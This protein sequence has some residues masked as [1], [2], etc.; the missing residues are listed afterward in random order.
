VVKKHLKLWLKKILGN[1]PKVGH[2]DLFYMH[3]SLNRLLQ[4]VH[5]LL[6]KGL[7]DYIKTMFIVSCK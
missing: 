2:C 5:V 1:V 3:C 6:L 4:D 7:K